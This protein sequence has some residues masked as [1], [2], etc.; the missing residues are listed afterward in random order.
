[1]EHRPIGSKSGALFVAAGILLSRIAG[2]VRESV[3]AHYFGNTEVADAF[4]A[5][6]R[7]PNLLQNL[8]G[9]GVLSASFIPV[10]SGLN[11]QEKRKEA[12]EVASAVGLI[13]ALTCTALSLLGILFTPLLIDLITPGFSGEKRLLAI[14]LVRI[15]FP[16]TALLVLSAWCL[17]ILNSHRRFF[18]SYAA[19][20]IWN[21]T[22]ILSLFVFGPDT[23][24]AK[25]VTPAIYVAWGVTLGSLLQF[26]SQLPKALRLLGAFHW[27]LG[28][29]LTSL[30]EV[31]RNFV[32]VVIGRG[33]VQVSAFVDSMIASLLPGGAIAALAY[34]QIIYFLPVSLFGMSVSAAELPEMSETSRAGEERDSYIRGRLEKG[35]RQISFFV[36]PAAVSFFVLGDVLIAALY[37]SGRFTHD[38]TLYVWATLAGLAIGLIA[39]TQSRLYASTFYALRDTRTPLRFAATRVATGMIAGC[40]LALGLPPLLGIAP[41][42]GIVGLTSA[43]GMSAWLEYWLLQRAVTR[44]IGRLQDNRRHTAALLAVACLSSLPALALHYYLPHYR[45]LVRAVIVLAPFGLSYIYLAALAGNNEAHKI[46][47]RLGRRA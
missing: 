46:I 26:L 1:M 11:S 20:V 39:S 37:Q 27:T 24:S 41:S 38:D 19:P 42:W 10:Y 3:F 21:L 34:A 36:I 30:R 17:G 2:F 15:F 44:R 25:L 23:E 45:P 16:G 29:H 12:E 43:A 9:E 4:K 47:H 40:S 31:M 6:L 22:I 35:L 7:I 13:L 33:V 28:L 18:L 14:H 8:F 5:A 32:P